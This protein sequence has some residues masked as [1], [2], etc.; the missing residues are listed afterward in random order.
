VTEMATLGMGQKNHLPRVHPVVKSA[1][2]SSSSVRNRVMVQLISTLTRLPPRPKTT[3][4]RV[5]QELLT[6]TLV[7]AGTL[8]RATGKSLSSFGVGNLRNLLIF[9]PK[10]SLFRGGVGFSLSVQPVLTSCVLVLRRHF[11]PLSLSL[12]LSLAARGSG[13]CRSGPSPSPSFS[14]TGRSGRSFTTRR[15]RVG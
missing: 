14:S 7:V 6:A 9:L 5:P 15:W 11:F 3:T 13:P 12:S 10:S 2:L 4:G 8:S 1:P